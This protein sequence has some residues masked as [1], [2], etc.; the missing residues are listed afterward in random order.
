[1]KVIIA[2][3]N[4][5]K[6]EEMQAIL[7]KFGMDAVSQEACGVDISVEE[8]G[9]TF[10]ENSELKARAIF[11]ATGMPVIADDSGLMVD[12]LDGAPGVYS[13]RFGDLGSD[14]ER[15]DY[16]MELLRDV[17]D[18]Q[19]GAHYV[20]A[21]TFLFPDGRKITAE[22]TCFGKILREYRGENGFGYDPMFLMEDTGM[23]FAELSAEQKNQISHR[24]NALRELCGKL[25]EEYHHADQ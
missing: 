25:R 1:M 19:R 2:S 3:K 10:A 23:T 4:A 9:T 15:N 16:L 22:G 17:P 5:H 18:A 20:C 7:R 12:A 13:H 24:A 11:E 6:I 8:T 14:A 21:I